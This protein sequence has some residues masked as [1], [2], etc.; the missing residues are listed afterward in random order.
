MMRFQYY[1]ELH[2]IIKKKATCSFQAAGLLAVCV[3]IVLFVQ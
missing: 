1:V 2:Q 3:S